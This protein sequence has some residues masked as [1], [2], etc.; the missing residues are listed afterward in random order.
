MY[1]E[2]VLNYIKKGATGYDCDATLIAIREVE[3]NKEWVAK[4]YDYHNVQAGWDEFYKE[5]CS[6][7]LKKEDL[8]MRYIEKAVSLACLEGETNVYR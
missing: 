7:V 5:C 6:T 4:H 3:S 8:N 1:Y 2:K